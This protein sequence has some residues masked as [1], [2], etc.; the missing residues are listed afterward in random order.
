MAYHLVPP[1]PKFV[2]DTLDYLHHKLAPV[3]HALFDSV[4]EINFT[5]YGAPL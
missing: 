3:H 1:K 4:V 5:F 2:F